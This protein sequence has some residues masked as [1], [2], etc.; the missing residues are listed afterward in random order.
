HPSQF[1]PY[2]RSSIC[3]HPL[4]R[5]DLETFLR[6]LGL[7]VNEGRSGYFTTGFLNRIYLF[8]DQVVFENASAQ[9]P[10]KVG[11]ELSQVPFSDLDRHLPHQIHEEGTHPKHVRAANHSDAT[12]FTYDTGAGTDHDD[13]NIRPR[14]AFPFE[15]IYDD[16]GYEFVKGQRR[17]ALK[18]WLLEK[19]YVA[20][21]T[22][23]GLN[24]VNHH[25]IDGPA[26]GVY[27]S[28]R[29]AEAGWEI[30]AH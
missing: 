5:P 30:P 29:K 20:A 12:Q 15:E 25:H 1:S 6:N 24:P 8:L 21:K 18:Q 13:P 26:P 7:W 11:S 3:Y 16:R 28:L 27:F 14:R 9:I 22:W 17:L 10:I 2:Y 4:S 23:L 19:P